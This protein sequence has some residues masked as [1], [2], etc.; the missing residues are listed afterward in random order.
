MHHA[1]K[2]TQS[3]MYGTPIHAVSDYSHFHSGAMRPRACDYKSDTA[4]FGML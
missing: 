2:P 4:P 1:M 3:A